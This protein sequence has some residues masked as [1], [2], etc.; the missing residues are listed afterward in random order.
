MNTRSS[1][2]VKVRGRIR[3]LNMTGNLE[4]INNLRK[5]IDVLDAAGELTRVAKE[6]DPV[7]EISR[8]TDC[9]SKKPQGG[10]ALFFTHVHESR[11]P[12]AT[13]LFGSPRRIRMALNVDEL[14]DLGRRV[15]R[16]IDLHPPR[17]FKDI[18][19]LIPL[20]T[21]AVF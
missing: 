8:L 16:Y 15:Q 7:L 6:V 17:S 13:N 1:I 10:K 5:F 19:D 21:D 20:V 3:S 12:V 18:L 2:Q 9:E 4:M 14:D 11:F